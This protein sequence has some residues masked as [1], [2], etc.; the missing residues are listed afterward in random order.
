MS[1]N[2][3][4]EKI[5]SA[6]GGALAIGVLF[7]SQSVFFDS[8][9]LL[10]V[11]SMGAS[12]VLL[13]AVPHGNLSQPWPLVGGHFISAVIGVSCYQWIPN[14]SLAA[15]SA[16]GLAI[17]AMYYSR[18]IHPPG[19]ATALTAVIGGEAITSLGYQYVVMPVLLNTSLLLVI[20]IIFNYG[21]PWRRYPAHLATIVKPQSTIPLDLEYALRQMGSFIDV[22]HDDLKKIFALATESVKPVDCEII[23]VGHYYSNG[24]YG[25]DWSI[26]QVIAEEEDL[27]TYKIVIGKARHQ[28]FT[29]S[30]QE[31]RQW[32]NYEVYRDENCWR[33]R[34]IN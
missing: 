20:A 2:H 1:I 7:I 18:C 19:G 11:G 23:Y 6:S 3:H 30:R 17:L 14:L 31:F 5:L 10:V 25:H 9:N 13:F 21:F 22:S 33:R 15:A 34:M 12:A 28:Q 8:A 16:V 26:R 24:R 27:L 4:Q 32:A 29:C